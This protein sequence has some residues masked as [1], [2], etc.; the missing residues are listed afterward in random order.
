[1]RV[2]LEE[3]ARLFGVPSE[4]LKKMDCRTLTRRYRK[5]AQKHH[6]DKGGDPERFIRLNAAYQKLLKRKSK[7]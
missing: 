7:Q 2:N 6:P 4:T 3:S 5:V 1:V